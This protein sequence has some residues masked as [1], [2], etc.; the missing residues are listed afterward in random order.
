[1][2]TNSQVT[3]APTRPA[4]VAAPAGAAGGSRKAW[5]W[6]RGH[7][8][9]E[10]GIWIFIF[11]DMCLYGVLF[12][13]YIS[14]R[15][16]HP[17]LFNSSSAFLTTSY[18]AVNTLLLLTSSL[19][20][21]LALRAVREQIAVERAPLLLKIAFLC[22]VGFVINKVLEYSDL[23]S[24]HH[25]PGKSLFFTYFFILTGIHLTHLLAGMGVLVFLHKLASKPSR[26][27]RDLRA[28]ES[29]AS[30]WHVVDLLWIVLFPLFYFVR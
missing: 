23:I 21:A 7:I 6:T 9:G 30:F 4:P 26:T 15:A 24:A 14:D 20:V 12:G 16:K 25:T 11:G 10:A 2:A 28:M 29:G 27:A 3:K 13:T 22:G 17:A 18:G 5:L 1:M 19:C 8:P